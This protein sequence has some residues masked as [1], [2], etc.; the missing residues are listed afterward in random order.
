M[1][2]E[3]RCP[4]HGEVEGLGLSEGPLSNAYPWVVV[5]EKCDGEGHTVVVGYEWEGD[6]FST[7]WEDAPA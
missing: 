6:N 7:R 5:C 3:P 2:A 1:A 4:I